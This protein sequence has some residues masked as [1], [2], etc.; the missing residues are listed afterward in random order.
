MRNVFLIAA[1]NIRALL[2]RRLLLALMLVLLIVTVILSFALTQASRAMTQ[3][4][5][6]APAAESAEQ[7]IIKDAPDAQA[8]REAMEQAQADMDE[9]QREEVRRSMQGMGTQM[10]SAF[11]GFTT[12][13]G[14]LVALFI[15]ATAVSTDVRSGAITMVLSKPVARWQFLMGKYSGAM[16]VLLAYSVLIGIAMVIFTQMH[17]LDSVPAIRYAPWL[18]FCQC[19]I[20]GSL[21]LVLSTIMHPAFA[22]VV[23]FFMQ[24]E[25][26]T[27]FLR[28]ENPFY[29]L[30]FLLP[31]YGPYDASEQFATSGALLGWG[32]VGILTVYALDLTVIYLLLAMWR[33]RSRAVV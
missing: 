6:S 18:L 15:G 2:H 12:F 11:Y 5:Q 20:Y 1:D 23:A 3:V 25:W 24:A 17:Q 14:I 33:F 26:L 27:L 21:A 13:G 31:S 8:I 32:E 16:A 22:G 30:S 19:L 9:E 7:E 4:S 10:L 28:P 29:Y